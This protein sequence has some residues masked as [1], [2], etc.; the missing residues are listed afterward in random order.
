MLEEGMYPKDWKKN[1]IN[2]IEIEQEYAAICQYFESLRWNHYEISNW[3]KPEYESVHNR[4][5]WNHT[6]Y[7]GFGLSA[8]SYEDG[9]RWENSTSFSHYYR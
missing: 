4:G 2:E 7:R 8:T 1:S 6:N 3:A 5:Y 9:K